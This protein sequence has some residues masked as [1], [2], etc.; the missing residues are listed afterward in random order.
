[1]DR[2]KNILNRIVD[3][4]AINFT[5][6]KLMDVLSSISVSENC[7]MGDLYMPLRYLLSGTN[8]GP[9]IPSIMAVLGKNEVIERLNKCN[10]FRYSK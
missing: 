7:T 3:V 10:E 4:E 1:V 6:E 8:V 9:A 2:V 5:S